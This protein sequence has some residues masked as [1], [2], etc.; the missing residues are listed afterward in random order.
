MVGAEAGVVR[1]VAA[2]RVAGMAWKR[3]SMLLL[4]FTSNLVAFEQKS[5]AESTS[6]Y[7]TD[8][9]SSTFGTGSVR[10]W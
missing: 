3:I 1:D 5:M 7:G 9:D 6:L 8:S 10:L 4:F 2:K